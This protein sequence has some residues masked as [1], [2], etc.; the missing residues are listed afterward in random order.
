MPIMAW[1]IGSNGL[2]TSSSTLEAIHAISCSTLLQ[3]VSILVWTCL[4][5]TPES[6]ANRVFATILSSQVI[7][8]DLLSST[9]LVF[10]PG[11]FDVL[12]V[13]TPPA[14]SY[15]KTFPS[16]SFKRWAIYLL[17]LE[18]L[19]C[20]P[21]IYI[22][23]GTDARS[24]V[25][26]RFS[27]YDKGKNLPRFIAQALN[28]DYTIQYKGLL[29]WTSLPS[30][31]MAPIVR[32]LFVAVEATFSWAMNCKTEYGYGM[33]DMCPWPRD[34][35]E[36]DGCGSHHPLSESPAGDTGLSAEELE[37]QALEWTRIRLDYI[38]KWKQ[39]RAAG[40]NGAEYKTQVNAAKRAYNKR[41]PEGSKNATKRS[42]EKSLLLKQYY[43]TICDK[44]FEHKTKLTRHLAT[45]TH[46][47][48]AQESSSG[49][50]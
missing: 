30:A 37:A 44:A 17:V 4:N 47:A 40:P 41:K 24:G 35:L 5:T 27:Q 3:L 33:T 48:K 15:F 1:M 26:A 38:K 21:R 49:S 7:I 18:K 25:S 43:C 39:D 29:C 2:A 14:V 19:N 28:E 31:G 12:Q 8:D 6:Q 13:S 22:G 45:A 10:A 23:S 34:K 50:S 20:R 36:Y 9:S 32:L 11:L 16:E 42:R 46:A